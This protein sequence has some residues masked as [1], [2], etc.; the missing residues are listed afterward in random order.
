MPSKE[1]SPARLD[2][3]LKR[4][5]VWQPPQGFARTV[6][7]GVPAVAR[8]W[9]APHR[10]GV[11]LFRALAAGLATAGAAY[12]VGSLLTW[13]AL[14]TINGATT[15]ADRYVMFIELATHTL[16][17]NT[18]AIALMSAVFSLSLAVAV[19]RRATA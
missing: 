15:V 17:A 2:E 11:P 6:V 4:Q 13:G 10:R 8:Q 19:T 1:I 14:L 3:A 18:T 5:A 9:P 12:L 16:I 7:A